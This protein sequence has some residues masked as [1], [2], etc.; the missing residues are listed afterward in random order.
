MMLTQPQRASRRRNCY[1][2]TSRRTVKSSPRVEVDPK[3][4]KMDARRRSDVRSRRLKSKLRSR[5]DWNWDW[6]E[7]AVEIKIIQC[8]E[9][10]LE[11][12]QDKFGR[13]GIDEIVKMSKFEWKRGDSKVFDETC[14][15]KNRGTMFKDKHDTSCWQLVYWTR[16]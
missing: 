16:H 10:R 15:M 14:S 5:I 13:T 7:N 9:V 1:M 12:G 6:N 3:Q 2:K 4:T 8:D 11:C